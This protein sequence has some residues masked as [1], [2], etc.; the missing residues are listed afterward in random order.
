MLR[1]DFLALIGSRPG[2]TD[3]IPVAL[4]LKNGY[5]VAGFFNTPV[6]EELQG[7]CVLVNARMI[8]LR[9]TT[10]AEGSSALRD[11]GDFL[12][13]IAT[14]LTRQDELDE[15][16]NLDASGRFGASIPLTAIPF[17]EISVVY[18]VSRIS[19]LMRR[20]E[21]VEDRIPT[22]LDFEN[23]SE[24]VKLLKTKLW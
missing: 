13:A 4:L 24:I 10:A 15:E 7:T 17:D 22:F 2:H 3:Y 20:V 12:Q 14:R 8:D 16:A 5:G 11:F 1:P 6:N 21:E 18:P 19:T 9:P 23:R